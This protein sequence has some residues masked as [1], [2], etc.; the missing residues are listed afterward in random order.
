MLLT[1][2]LVLIA[3]YLLLSVT[4]YFCQH[5][6]FFRPEI[7]SPA[8]EYDYPFPFDELTF[9]ME[10]GGSINAIY[11]K[12]PNAKG[13]VFYLKGNSR[14]IKGWGKFAKDFVGKGYDYFMIDYRG[15]GKSTGKRNESILYK[16]AQVVYDWVRERYAEKDIVIYG[17]SFGT[18]IAARMAAD[19]QPAMLILDS[20]YYSFEYQIKR[21]AWWLPLRWLLRYKLP[22]YKFL[23]RIS[24]PTYVIHGDKDWLI[25]YEQGVK[26]ASVNPGKVQLITIKGG[27]HNNLPE[28][29]SYHDAVYGLL[30][31]ER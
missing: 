14:S 8:F 28:F 10:D 26:L 18:G 12:V 3:L 24:C 16:D 9:D 31:E 25:S 27:W 7:L 20:P 17:R 6:A 15:F 5:L 1:I 2:G 21:F 22:T 4:F 29:R 30:N 23:E 11:F 13:V 19:N